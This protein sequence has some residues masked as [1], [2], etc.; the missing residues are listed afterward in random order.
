MKPK[1]T[2]E[3]LNNFYTKTEQYESVA[4]KNYDVIQEIITNIFCEVKGIAKASLTDL[5]KLNIE[6]CTEIAVSHIKP[7]EAVTF[8]KIKAVFFTEAPAKLESCVKDVFDGLMDKTKKP[9]DKE[10]RKELLS[11]SYAICNAQ[12]KKAKENIIEDLVEDMTDAMFDNMVEA[13][14]EKRKKKKLKWISYSEASQKFSEI[15]KDRA[16]AKDSDPFYL[17]R[18]DGKDKLGFFTTVQNG[19]DHFIPMEALASGNGETYAWSEYEHIHEIKNFQIYVADGHNHQIDFR[20]LAKRQAGQ[21]EIQ[22]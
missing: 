20:W 13:V 7:E 1:M 5:Q 17:Y 11:R 12:L 9:V 15:F 18:E 14:K 10:K 21:G 16:I 4:S 6:S 2:I 3:E 8:E 22:F 19:H